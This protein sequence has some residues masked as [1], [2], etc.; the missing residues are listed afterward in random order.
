M[1]H[2]QTFQE[3]A[4]EYG[5]TIEAVGITNESE[6]ASGAAALAPLGG[7]GEELAGY[8]G[9]GYA[10]VVEILSAALSAGSFL[11]ML[12]G[13]TADGTAG[14]Y[15]LGHFFLVINPEAF[16]GLD[17]FKKTC[18]DIL[19]ELRAS[20]K[21]PG[22]DRIYTAGEKEYLTWLERKDKGVP[23]GPAVQKELIEIRDALG[24]PH[25]FPFES[26]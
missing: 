19:R 16:V 18:G 6:V 13:K 17:S 15:H 3:L 22:H 14:P 1:A 21:A 5:F 12:T 26:R 4:P 25:I 23:V 7:I 11:K 8:K 24:L 20:Q 9:Y 10:T 2:L